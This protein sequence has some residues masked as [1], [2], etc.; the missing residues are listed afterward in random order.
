VASFY[1]NISKST[2]LNENLQGLVDFLEEQTGATG[3]YIGK[4]VFPRK[5]IDEDAPDN[6]HF[7]EEAPKVIQY[8]HATKSHHKMV[9]C[10]ITAETGPCTHSVFNEEEEAQA[11]DDDQDQ[12]NPKPKTN[13][14]LSTFKHMYVPEVV[15]DQRMWFK[16]V[17]RLGSFMAV[18]LV[19]QSCLTDDALENAITDFQNI[20][21]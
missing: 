14:I 5:P 19:Y 9:D 10:V 16:R 12:E 7:D 20:T 11:E 2:D 6:A 21:L 15:R 3:V 18:P 17:P 13:D 4:L 1:D 8:T